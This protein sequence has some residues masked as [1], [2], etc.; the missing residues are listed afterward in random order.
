MDIGGQLA[1]P[2]TKYHLIRRTMKEE[3]VEEKDP[4]GQSYL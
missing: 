3:N 4:R 1:F 2:S